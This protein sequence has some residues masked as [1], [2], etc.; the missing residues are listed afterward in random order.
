MAGEEGHSKPSNLA[1]KF[2]GSIL[3]LELFGLDVENEPNRDT[4]VDHLN[5]AVT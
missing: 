2:L 5:D 3:K 4:K 1:W